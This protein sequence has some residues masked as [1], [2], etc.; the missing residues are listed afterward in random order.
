MRVFGCSLLLLVSATIPACGNGTTA[1][2]DAAPASAPDAAPAAD[3]APAISFSSDVIPIFA[4]RCSAAPQ[5][6]DSTTA[7]QGLDLTAPNAFKDIVNVPSTECQNRLIVAPGDPAS[8]YLI[9][10][11]H[12]TNLCSGV[13]MPRGSALTDQQ[14]NIISAWISAGAKNN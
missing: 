1:S 8:S 14:I 9:D 10:K 11:L 6:H 5:C 13:R 7:V 2:T 12:G 3:A 4:T